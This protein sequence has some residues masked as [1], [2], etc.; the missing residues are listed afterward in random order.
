MSSVVSS[1]PPSVLS[2]S[3]ILAVSGSEESSV[4]AKANLQLFSL[5]DAVIL[6]YHLYQQ[7]QQTSH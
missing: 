5:V 1:S 6:V 7:Q 2:S 3:L 4:D